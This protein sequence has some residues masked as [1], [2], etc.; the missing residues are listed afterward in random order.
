LH[1]SRF[2]STPLSIHIWYFKFSCFWNFLLEKLSKAL[3]PHTQ[4]EPLSLPLSFRDVCPRRQSLF[5]CWVSTDSPC[6]DKAW[7]IQL[8]PFFQNLNFYPLR[9]SPHGACASTTQQ[10]LL[11]QNTPYL[12]PTLE[13]P[14][15]LIPTLGNPLN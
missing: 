2:P 8:S 3:S 1:P 9:V 11:S 6:A 10:V 14:T 7:F 12:I 4:V 13:H 5:R 15:T